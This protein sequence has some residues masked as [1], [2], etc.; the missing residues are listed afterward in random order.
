MANITGTLQSDG[1]LVGHISSDNQG[2]RGL[3][4]NSTPGLTAHLSN[5]TLRGIPVELRV[6]ETT[7]Q[8][9][10]ED[11]DT[12]QDLINLNDIDYEQLKNLPTVN[13]SQII[14]EVSSKFITPKDALTNMEIENLLRNN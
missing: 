1:A 13:G 4:N 10:Y 3:L 2:L 6:T 11:E 9:K 14:K 12:W 7:L 8:W 5:A